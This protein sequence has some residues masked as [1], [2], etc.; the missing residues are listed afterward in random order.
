MKEDNE[1]VGSIASFLKILN[2]FAISHDKIRFY[3]GQ[4]ETDWELEPSLL[5]KENQNLHKREFDLLKELHIHYPEAFKDSKNLFEDLVI[6]QHYGIP[7]RLLDV[8]N[9]PLVALYFAVSDKKPKTGDAEVFII[10][11]PKDAVVYYD[12][13]TMLLS[14]RD[15][16]ERGKTVI[17]FPI[18]GVKARLNNSRI[19][20]QQGA[21]IYFAEFND[22]SRNIIKNSNK[23]VISRS[24]ISKIRDEL[25]T[26]GISTQTLFP[27]ISEFKKSFN[28]GEIKF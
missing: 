7:T 18:I 2:R 17:K 4:S 25:S 21:F 1:K 23:I 28:K 20:R 26:L 22:N 10:D 6:A 27:E 14:L 19:I 3:R 24:H 15:S 9:N 16:I 11:I 12:N 8:T 13:E 5:R